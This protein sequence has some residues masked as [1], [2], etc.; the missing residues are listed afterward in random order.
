[1][2]CSTSATRAAPY[3]AGLHGLPCKHP[4][5]W[6]LI[7]IAPITAERSAAARRLHFLEA[8]VGKGLCCRDR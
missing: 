8:A 1:M 7:Y 4:C 2:L 3:L 5:S 6:S